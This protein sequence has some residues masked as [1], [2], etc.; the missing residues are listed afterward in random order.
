[1]CDGGKGEIKL[2]CIEGDSDRQHMVSPVIEENAKNQKYTQEGHAS[3]GS[4]KV[5][6][7]TLHS[8][9]FSS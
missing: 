2:T 8:S 9:S 1:M 7:A 5:L 4:G 6:G 3:H